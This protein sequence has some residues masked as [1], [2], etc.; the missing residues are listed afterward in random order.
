MPL[1]I[2][3]TESG[4]FELHPVD[5]WMDGLIVAIEETEGQWGPGL[6]WIIELD[7]DEPADDGSMPEVWAFCS[8]KLSP[9]SKLYGWLKGLDP[10]SI[11]EAGAAVDLEQFIG[12]RAQ[13]MFERYEGS[14]PDGNALEKEKVIKLRAGKPAEKKRVGKPAKDA[15][16]DA[17]F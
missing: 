1:T 2:T 15:D 13:V 14:D 3:A 11:P 17:P 5:E 9:R 6:K 10:S 4:S 8:Q 16:D 12:A 7:G